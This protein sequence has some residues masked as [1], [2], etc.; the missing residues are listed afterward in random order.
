MFLCSDP[1]L[2]KQ[3]NLGNPLAVQTLRL[4]ASTAGGMGLTPD[5]GAVVSCASGLQLKKKKER[6]YSFDITYNYHKILL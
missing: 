3:R 6:I 5:G 1:K 2:K 4:C